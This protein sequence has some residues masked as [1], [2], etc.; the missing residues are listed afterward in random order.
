[1]FGIVKR[2][3]EGELPIDDL[4]MFY[5]Q[6]FVKALKTFG[7]M[8]SPPSLLDLNVELLKHGAINTLMSICFLPFSFIDWETFK[9]EDLI[10]ND[11]ESRK[12]FKVKMYEHPTVKALLQRDMKSWV[13][14]GWM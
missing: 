7:Y 12:N 14:K 13:N 1:M 8:R 5:H 4:I 6:N 11:S 9:V 3:D 2:D 10:G